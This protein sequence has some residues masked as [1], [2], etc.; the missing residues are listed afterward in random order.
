MI[1][2]RTRAEVTEY[3]A[4]KLT[5]LAEKH[6]I[7]ELRGHALTVLTLNESTA[8]AHRTDAW[9]SL[10]ANFAQSDKDLAI[11]SEALAEVQRTERLKAINALLTQAELYQS[12]GTKADINVLRHAIHLIAQEGDQ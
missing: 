11:F 3:V 6:G 9:A 5:D 1:R 8:E 7:N 2:K 12:I 10:V 4:D